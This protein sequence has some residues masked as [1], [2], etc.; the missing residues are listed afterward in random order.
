MGNEEKLRGYLKRV[1]ADLQRTRR[2]L[3]EAE[4]QAHE[5]VAVVAMACRYPGGVTSPEELWDLVADGRDA[6]SEFPANRGWDVDALY[7]PD[8]EATGRSYT[9]FGG[10]LHDADLFDA[11]HFGMNPREA[12]ATDPQQRVLLEICWEALERAGI[13]VKD[14]KGSDTGT[15]VG[16]MYDDYGSRLHTVP[17]EFEGYVGSG[18]APSVASGRIA[19]TFGLQGPAVT[20]DTACSSSLV[21][22]HMAVQSLRRRECSLA[23]AGGVTIMAS[24]RTFV[25]FSR[26][27]GLAPDGR[28]KPFSADADG[29]GW[30]EGA[31]V[32]LLERLSDAERAGHPVLAV[33]TGSAVNQDGA[34]SRLTAPH[35]PSQ[36]RVIRQALRA[37]RLDPADVD[38]VEA[39]GTGTALGDPIEAQALQAVY[40]AGRDAGRPLWLGAVK[41][42]LGHTQAAAGAAGVIKTVMAIRH[43]TLPRTLHAER[44]LDSVD[45][46]SGGVSLLTGNRPWTT[47]GAPRRAAVSSFGISGTNAHVVVEQYTPAEPVATTGPVA[48]AEP[49]SVTG[50]V[51]PAEPVATTGPV[52]PAEPGSVVVRP[53]PAEPAPAAARPPVVPLL[54]SARGKDALGALAG[55]LLPLLDGADE[56]SAASLAHALATGRSHFEHRA[57]AVGADLPALTRALTA[58]AHGEE[59]PGLVRDVAETGR[60]TVFVFPGQGSQWAGMAAELADTDE[61]FAASLRRCADALRPYTDW[62]LLAVLRGEPDAPSLERVDVVQPALFAVMV[63]L[64]ELWRAHGVRPAAVIGHSQGEIAAACVAGALSLDDAARVVALRSRALAGLSGTGGMLSVALPAAEVTRL[65]PRWEGRIGVAAVN[66]PRSTVVSGDRA[67]LE[68]LR[69]HYDTEGVRARMVPVD[70]AS[71][72]DHV[73][74]LREELTRALDGLRPRPADT[75]FCSTVTGGPLDTALLDT[76]YWFRNL[77]RPVRL[78]QAVRALLDQEYDCFVEISPHPVLTIGLEETIGDHGA[79]AV[80]LE[81]LRRDDGGPRRF[82]TSLA[83]AHTAGVDVDWTPALPDTDAPRPQL[84][85]YPFQRRRH[86]IDAVEPAA[87]AARLG[88]ADTAHDLLGASVRLAARGELL[89]TGAVGPDTHPWLRDH[90]V[91]GTVLVPGAALVDIALHAAALVGAPHLA[92]LDLLTPLRLPDTGVRLQAVVGAPD[93]DGAR[94]VEI[95][96]TPKDAAEDGPWT[97]HATATLA[98][99]PPPAQD[100]AVRPPADAV[101]VDL[102]GHYPALAERGYDYGPAFRGLRAAWRHGDEVYAEVELGEEQRARADAFTVHPALLDA[103]LHAVAF[104]QRDDEPA[105]QLPFSWSGVSLWATGA[106]RLTARL[107]R[108]A[109]GTYR[110]ELADSAG[111][112]ATVESLAL[113]PAPTGLAAPHGTEP[114]HLYRVTWLPAPTGVPHPDPETY[115]VLGANVP[116]AS[117]TPHTGPVRYADWDTLRSALDTGTPAPRIVLADLT[118]REPGAAPAEAARRAV[119]SALSLARAWQTDDR[120]AASRLVFLTRDAVATTTGG[121]APDPAQAAVWGLVRSAQAEDQGRFG[122]LDTDGHDASWPA[123]PTALTADEPQLAVREGRLL[124]PRLARAGADHD[125]G[126][127]LPADGTPWRLDFAGR[128]TL[129]DLAVVAA[130]EATAPLA[131]GQV[132]VR[133]RAAGVNF[134]DVLM[135]LGM[136]PP[137]AG[138]PG[139]EGAGIVTEIGEGVTGLVPGDRVMG[140]FSGGI[141]PVTVADARLVTRV[142][143]TLTLA[144]AAAV[145]VA[146]LT[147]YYGLADLAGLTAGESVLVH[148]AAGAVGHAA[149]QL[150]RHWGADVHATASPAKWEAV[151]ALGVDPDRIASSRTL[152]FE[153]DLLKRTEGRGVDVVLNSLAREFVDASLRLLPR[154]GRFVEMGKTDIRDAE[155]IAASC[156]GVRYRAFDLGEAGPDR[157][158][159]MLDEIAALFDRGTLTPMPVAAWDVRH[160]PDAFRHLSQ[161]HNVGKVVLTLPAP[162]RPDGTVLVTG[163]LGT[164]GGHVARHL[165]TEHGA[166]RLLLLGRRGPDT[167]S[168]AALR[169]ELTA[170]GAQV[171]V[172]ACDTADRSALAGALASI[173]PEHPLVAVVHA[174]GVLDDAALASLTEER[175]DRVFRPKADAATHLDD[176]TRGLDLDAF[177]LFSSAAGVL[178]GA[179]QANY[180]AA[181]AFLDALAARR[182]AAGAPAV[183]LAWGLWAE[184]SGMTGHLADGDLARLRRAGVLPLTT[185]T[186]LALFDTALT[187][188]DALLVPTRLDLAA[189]RG[190]AAGALP[191]PLLRSLAGAPAARRAVAGPAAATDGTEPLA[192]RLARMTAAERVRTLH[193]LV[194]TQVAAALGHTS[195]ESVDPDATFKEAGFDSL[196]GVE[197]RNRLGAATGLRLPATLVFDEPTPTAL[198]DHLLARLAP[199]TP[200]GARQQA[201]AGPSLTEEIDRLARLL[202]TAPP[203]RDD[204]AVAVRLRGLVAQW[205][206]RDGAGAD[207]EEPADLADADDEA[208]FDVLDGELGLT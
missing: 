163:A 83:R 93:T 91:A 112:V 38:L 31:G 80:V 149:V 48:P 4:E 198:V 126:L 33:L 181:N 88:L 42:N 55:R 193:Q 101:P 167:P 208:L 98:T 206:G 1:T 84:P 134:R 94:T 151:R 160:A 27:R 54:V 45:W 161:G 67:A 201:P 196:T 97:H 182:R 6:V 170:L 9:R 168:A 187:G 13:G 132:R 120:L 10:F 75:V 123:L 8:P 203:G 143:A 16:V 74:G 177:V 102:T 5:P 155:E 41:S 165:V 21:A 34:S 180:A 207:R 157:I 95:H 35:G 140:L 82:L 122:L 191:T 79:R 133:M 72:S 44:P 113:R 197:L 172:V 186:G 14:V 12:T 28:C 32:L 119:L 173:P 36:Q 89:L 110:L 128:R 39:H 147:A 108:L 183:S 37:A 199:T 15:F 17:A 60:R 130:P 176:L 77:R 175:I 59:D 76:D 26:Q 150:A 20:V 121:T 200:G 23:L 40:G 192:D 141:G 204:G 65:L 129:E 2:R 19:Y 68:E 105:L 86:W 174:A 49:G 153:A 58:L 184:R 135:T 145:P 81:S 22:L 30:S 63:S 125:G 61:E 111:L 107:T 64:A 185:Q 29:T 100:T 146:Y 137:T 70:Y 194:R 73:E 43:A 114:D 71:H 169:D 46:A 62:D 152:D 109:A 159:Q 142:P 139:G 90:R 53:A 47:D 127:R 52:A 7:D 3:E 171:D 154:G 148:T 25:E 87:G 51:A 202:L 136:V 57:V 50:P 195:A 92:T 144:Q 158:R 205:D 11:A 104:L 116:A 69:S 190:C 162:P 117:A 138:L 78:E 189:L 131:A 56:A 164:L 24:P 18:S 156:P 85:T 179:G 166:R 66:G 188:A 99:T 96:S 103:A 124:A 115:A 106:T 178:G 118:D